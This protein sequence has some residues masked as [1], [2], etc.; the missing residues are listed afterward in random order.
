M[1]VEEMFTVTTEVEAAVNSRPMT[2]LYSDIGDGNPLTPSH[3]LVGHRLLALPDLLR[4]TDMDYIPEQSK[5]QMTK[6][7]MIIS[8]KL[9]SFWNCWKKEYLVNLR[10]FDQKRRKKIRASPSVGEVAILQDQT[11]RTQWKLC[12]I[13]ELISGK[14]GMVRAV[15]VRMGNGTILRRPIQHLYSLEIYDENEDQSKKE[16]VKSSQ[17]INVSDGPCPTYSMKSERKSSTV[18]KQKI[19]EQLNS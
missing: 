19:R 12:R 3:F 4:E 2:Y 9:K 7:Y 18:A 17:E 15:K 1:S 5:K 16:T 13:E 6:N 14:D 11:P 10:E 8:N